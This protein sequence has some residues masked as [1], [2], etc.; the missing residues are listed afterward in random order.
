MECLRWLLLCWWDCAN[1]VFEM[2]VAVLVT[3]IVLMECLRWLLL[4]W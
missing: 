3:R 4:C 1:G 2:V